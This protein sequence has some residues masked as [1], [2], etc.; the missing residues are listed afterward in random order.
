MPFRRAETRGWMAEHHLDFRNFLMVARINEPFAR[1]HDK[2]H[3]LPIRMVERKPRTEIRFRLRIRRN[4]FH[5]FISFIL[6]AECLVRNF[7]PRKRLERFQ[8]IRAACTNRVR[9]KVIGLVHRRKGDHLEHVVLSDVPQ[10][11]D[12][13]IKR[14]AILDAD[15]LKLTHIYFFYQFLAPAVLKEVV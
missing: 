4:A 6:R 10:G 9:A 12:R 3:T 5:R 2:C 15:I 7:F 14:P 8:N 11:A 13:I 1:F